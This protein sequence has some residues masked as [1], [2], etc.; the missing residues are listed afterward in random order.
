MVD[1]SIQ[2][3]KQQGTYALMFKCEIPFLAVAGR[4]GSIQIDSGFWVYVGS[5]FGPGGL[6]SR[7]AHHLKPSTRPHWHLDYIKHALHPIE[8]WV[9]VDEVKRE[10]DWAGIFST[11][12]GA[13]RPIEGFGASDC[14]CLSHLIHLPR[15]PDYSTFLKQTGTIEPAN[16][17]F[18]RFVLDK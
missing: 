7:L 10:H 18:F 3:T 16:S 5:A 15:R 2:I 14:S 8:I 11:L 12:K 4:L 6:R 17:A 13:V 9:T 1:Q